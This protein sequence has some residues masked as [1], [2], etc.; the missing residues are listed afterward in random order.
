MDPFSKSA[1]SQIQYCSMNFGLCF[2]NRRSKSDPNPMISSCMW[3]N[4]TLSSLQAPLRRPRVLP[5]ATAV[6]RP[7][8]PP[9]QRVSLMQCTSSVWKRKFLLRLMADWPCSSK[10][11]FQ[12]A[13]SMP[14][15]S[16]V[17]YFK[18][19]SAPRIWD[20]VFQTEEVSFTDGL[21]QS[22]PLACMWLNLASFSLQL[23][24]GAVYR[25]SYTPTPP[26]PPFTLAGR[27][28]RRRLPPPPPPSPGRGRGLT[29]GARPW[30]S[31]AK[32]KGASAKLAPKGKKPKKAQGLL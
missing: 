24:S 5:P 14:S 12:H 17:S 21:F 31:V 18:C 30:R 6:V 11:F 4:L 1:S 10:S 15:V 19:N 29:R 16:F 32:G 2:S 7:P 27:G 25:A 23:P 28:Q 9:L 8:P 13:H 22:Y 20:C 3:L 26:L